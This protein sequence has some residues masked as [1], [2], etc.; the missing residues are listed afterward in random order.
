MATK[1]ITANDRKR[2][3]ESVRIAAREGRL[4]YHRGPVRMVA[5]DPADQ[6]LSTIADTVL[7]AVA[8]PMPKPA[9]AAKAKLSKHELA[10]QER[11]AEITKSLTLRAKA[12]C[13]IAKAALAMRKSEDHALAAVAALDKSDRQRQLD[14]L[15]LAASKGD[16]LARFALGIKFSK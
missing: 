13:N 5:N 8:P 12:G 3:A 7:A 6:Y 10:E 15:A 11:Q 9:K 16:N 14:Y 4:S 2:T 1:M